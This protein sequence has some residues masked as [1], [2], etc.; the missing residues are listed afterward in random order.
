MKKKLRL[1]YFFF[2]LSLVVSKLP[3]Q[4]V[5]ATFDGQLFTIDINTCETNQVLLDRAINLITWHPNGKM[6]ASGFPG[7]NESKNLY[8]VNLDNG[9]T[10]LVAVFPSPEELISE[11]SVGADGKIYTFNLDH[12]TSYDP[13][14]GQA[15]NIQ[16]AGTLASGMTYYE[17][18]LL[19]SNPFD[20][21]FSADI[22]AFANHTLIFPFSAFEENLF[23]EGLFSI[24][25]SCDSTT[26]Y[27]AMRNLSNEDFIY[28]INIDEQSVE[29]NCPI[30]QG[31]ISSIASPLEFYEP[32][33]LFT[34]DLDADDSSGATD[35]D[36]L[37]DTT[38]LIQDARISDEDLSIELDNGNIDSVLIFMSAIN[39]FPNEVL[40]IGGA[41][42]L[43]V[44][45]DNTAA[46]Q[47]STN[48]TSMTG[49]F[50]N[51][52]QML[53]LSSPETNPV[54]GVRKVGVVGWADGLQSDTAWACIPVFPLTPSAGGDASLVLCPE[55]E[56]VL[57]YELLGSAAASGGIWQ[58]NLGTAEGV[59]DPE[60]Q[61]EGTYIYIQT[62]G[63][64]CPADTA[65]VQV[66]VGDMPNFDLG[67]DTNICA[68]TNLILQVDLSE[69]VY[70]WQDGST[71]NSFLVTENGVYGLEVTTPEGCNARDT[72]EVT[73]VEEVSVSEEIH[74]CEGDSYDFEGMQLRR[75][76]SI[77]RVFP[78]ENACDSIWCLNLV[79]DL[80]PIVDLGSNQD[81]DIG[82]SIS[83]SAFTDPQNPTTVEWTPDDY[84]DCNTCL[85]VVSTPQEDITYTLRITDENGCVGIDEIDIRL[86][87]KQQ[88]FFP[89]VFTPNDDEI[90]DYFTA[91][92]QQGAFE[93]TLLRIFNRWGAV[94]FE[95]QNFSPGDK[96][97]FWDG[98]Y[99]G[100]PAPSGVYIYQATISWPNGEVELKSGDL[101]LVR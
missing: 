65:I 82:E 52:I 101:T 78:T 97:G 46:V 45:G 15:D 60:V 84:L 18:E 70:Q 33:C 92:G 71:A 30:L 42:N 29:L 8:E 10:T 39:S 98:Q 56:P 87:Q 36:Y 73:F 34:I 79:V 69:V 61:P 44:V 51:G 77:C 96:K 74:I 1:I 59:F 35:E 28:Q 21:L 58:P 95:G 55:D 72:I 41:T 6:Y 68:G 94:V 81:I 85:E 23:M 11:L 53:R 47:L 67:L 64:D 22:T 9:T 37:V 25:H 90:N 27:G 16:G 66:Q 91:Y 86:L 75:D 14:T 40:S 99:K 63:N 32:P 4:E 57:L 54:A 17:D 2:S 93:V 7:T 26:L 50:I 89:N 20:G 13:M 19:F 76:T 80:N 49:D 38:C 88:V 48:G 62:G 43:N 24:R 3:A 83:I 12:H 31:Q 5:F 100:K